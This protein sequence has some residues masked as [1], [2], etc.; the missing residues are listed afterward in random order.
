VLV[1][2]FRDSEGWSCG[3]VGRLL[4][5]R[6]D[7]QM[8][9]KVF[10]ILDAFEKAEKEYFAPPCE[11]VVAKPDQPVNTSPSPLL[12]APRVKPDP[13]GMVSIGHR[14]MWAR[15]IK[16]QA[17]VFLQQVVTTATILSSAGRSLLS[18]VWRAT[19]PWTIISLTT[20]RFISMRLR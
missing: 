15:S 20:A 16:D 9:A 19:P 7:T 18:A 2:C 1:T 14:L 5:D 4:V 10:K 11:A 17:K 13:D 8:S 3:L 12:L 6:L